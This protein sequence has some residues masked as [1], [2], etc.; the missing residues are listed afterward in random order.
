MKR[1]TDLEL[2][3]R[4]AFRR[5]Y[6][7]GLVDVFFGLVLMS[8]AVGAAASNW[9]ESEIAGTLIMLVV[10]FALVWLLLGQRRRLLRARLGDF[11]PGPERRRKISASR[12]ALVGSLFVGI[13]VS[14]LV[15]VADREGFSLELILP[16]LWFVNA[17]VVLGAMA[18]FLNVP[19]FYVHGF[20]FGLAMPLLILP[21]LLWGV[22][23]PPWFAF[24]VPGTVM[25]VVGVVKLL[26]F[27]RRYP[28]VSTDGDAPHG[29]R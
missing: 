8:M 22:R 27:L 5:F 7:D 12:L 24:G 1:L 6:D 28:P 15:W 18:H 2:L 20:L 17:V 11:E 29:G 14:A 10:A 4:S 3:E 13:L 25:V 19:R 9:L 26:G 16:L 21:D 23:I